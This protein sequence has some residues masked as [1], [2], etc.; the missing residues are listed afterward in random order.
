MTLD[1]QIWTDPQGKPLGPFRTRYF[2]VHY[3]LVGHG[4]RD[5]VAFALARTSNGR[6]H[7]CAVIVPHVR[8]GASCTLDSASPSVWNSARAIRT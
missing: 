1:P 7:G 2:V 6:S 8:G 5:G 4:D 3:S